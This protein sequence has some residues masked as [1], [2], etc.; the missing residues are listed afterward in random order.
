LINTTMSPG[1]Y[2]T[3]LAKG[4]VRLG[5]TP[6]LTVTADVIEGTVAADRTAANI[7]LRVLADLGITDIDSSSFAAL[8]TFNPAE[9]GVYVT[10]ETTALD[11]IGQVLDSIGA[12]IVPT[13]QGQFQVIGLAAPLSAQVV[14]TI[15][16]RDIV[17]GAT[18]AFGVGGEQ[19]GVP[20]WSVSLNYE[21]NYSPMSDGQ[22]AGVVT[23][24]ERLRLS[25]ATKQEVAQNAAIKIAHPLAQQIAVDS[26]LSN[27]VD[28]QIEAARRLAL[29][30]VKRD[31]FI[32]PVAY[33]KGKYEL[34]D[35]VTV[36]LDRFGYKAGKP[37]MVVGRTDD[38]TKRLITLTVWG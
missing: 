21:R 6:A 4:I 17:S 30:G 31:R 8:D 20:V 13:T 10:A 36:K 15:T 22:I 28:A 26:L 32:L 16:Q 11:V 24:P 3:C 34:G 2:A 5:G 37:M 38:F 1:E 25:T 7:V 23:L 14:G 18:F 27:Q 35:V 12:S 29:Y 9:I 33:D 19:E